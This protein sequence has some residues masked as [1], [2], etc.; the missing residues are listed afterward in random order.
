MHGERSVQRI[1]DVLTLESHDSRL[2]RNLPDIGTLEA[3]SANRRHRSV[4]REDSTN[5]S[6]M[7]VLH[8]KEEAYTPCNQ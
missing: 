8:D 3:R 4:T 6:P 2:L 5:A 1:G 7:R